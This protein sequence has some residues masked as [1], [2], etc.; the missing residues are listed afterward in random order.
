MQVPYTVLDRATSQRVWP[1]FH[2]WYSRT[3]DFHICSSYGLFRRMTG[4][5]GRPEVILEG[6]NSLSGPWKEYDFL[7]KPGNINV[8][9]SYISKFYFFNFI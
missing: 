7:H 6:S 1:V 8:M 9:P 4:V 3:G 5:D 2:H